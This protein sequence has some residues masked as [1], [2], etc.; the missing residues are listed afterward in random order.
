MAPP[1]LTSLSP[2]LPPT[3]GTERASPGTSFRFSGSETSSLICL[4]FFVSETHHSL[5]SCV[6]SV[7]LLTDI[8]SLPRSVPEGFGSAAAM[9]TSMFS[10]SNRSS[11]QAP[12]AMREAGVE[13]PIVVMAEV[14]DEEALEL[15]ARD[16]ALTV[17]LDGAG[18]QLTTHEFELLRL[19][20]KNAGK[21]LSREEIFRNLRGIEYDGLDRSIDGRISKL[22]RKLGDSSTEPARIKT[23]WGKGYL[24]VPDAWGKSG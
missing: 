23:V 3:R 7:R 5:R 22:R 1:V 8:H 17:W 21:V 19:L 24:L 9:N 11:P 18:V 2:P 12:V 20:A 10:S 6:S 13:K 15:A 14:S 16:V 4:L